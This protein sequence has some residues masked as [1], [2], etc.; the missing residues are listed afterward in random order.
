MLCVRA[1]LWS[2]LD[3]SRMRWALAPEVFLSFKSTQDASLCETN[4]KI[5]ALRYPSP[6]GRLRDAQDKVLGIFTDSPK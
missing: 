6:Q 2:G 4:R 3:G 1:R 5:P